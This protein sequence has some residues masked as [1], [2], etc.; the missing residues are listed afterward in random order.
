MAFYGTI[1][2]RS[3]EISKISSNLPRGEKFGFHIK[4]RVEER[5]SSSES[6][7]SQFLERVAFKLED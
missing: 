1:Q 2:I 4:G 5:M 6:N 7:P 3:N